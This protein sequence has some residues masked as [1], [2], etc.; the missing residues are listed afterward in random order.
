MANRKI[1]DLTALTAPATGDLL[2]IV[3][4]SEAAAADKNKKITYGELLASAPAGS[5]AAPS[6]SFDSDPNTGIYSPGADQV[7]ISTNGVARLTSSTTALTSAL[8]VD[9]PLGAAATP[10]LTFT[11]DLNTGIYSP[12][13]DQV[14]ISTGGTGRLF[15]DAAGLVGIGTSSPS[16]ILHVS[17]TSG[18]PALFE[19]TGSNG[20]FIGLKDGSVNNVFLGNTNGV[21]SVQ[22]PGSSFSDK[23]VVTSAGLVGIGTT[24]P[25]EKLEIQDGS[26]SVGS[27]ANTSQ[28]NTLI[29]GYGYILSG[30]KYGNT[31]IRSTYNN[32]NNLSSLEFYTSSSATASTE[33]LRI[34]SAGLVGVGTSAPA[35]TLHVAGT[36][37]NTGQA[38]LGIGEATTLAYIGDPFTTN[39]RSIIFN[40]ATGVTDIVNIQGL[41]AGVGLT[42]IALQAGGGRVGIGTSS[43]NAL[44]EVNSSTAGNE[45]QRIEGAYS[46]SGSV[47]LTNWRRAGGA[48][49]AAFKYND[50]TSPL[51]MSIGTTTSHQFRIRTADTDAITIDTS[52]RVGI[53]T[54]SPAAKLEVA[55]GNI[56]LDNNQGVEWGGVNNYIY[57]NESTDF[58]AV[59][60]NGN[61]RSR[62]D[63]SGRLL[64]GTST[65]LGNGDNVQ[66][67]KLQVHSS[68]Y[69]LADF[70]QYSADEYPSII[71]LEKS[72]N[73]SVG[74]HTALV[75]NDEIGSIR[76]AGSDGTRFQSAA[77]IVAQVDG[78]PGANDM[79]GRLVFSTTADGASSPTERMRIASNGKTTIKGSTS[80]SSAYSLEVTESG[81]IV[82]FTIRNDGIILTGTDTL[83]PYNNTTASAANLFVTSGGELQRST[84]S[85]KYKKNVQDAPYGLQELMALRAV[86]YQGKS[87][88]DGNT[89]YG[90]LIAEEVDAAGLQEFVQYADDGTPDALAYGNMV[91]LCIK[92]IQEQQAMI[93]ELQ[94]KVA[95]FESA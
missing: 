93:A 89:V 39:T 12:G 19:R 59:A 43:V 55:G 86:T 18:T 23:L 51:C 29:A 13:A 84:S 35:S 87:A 58:I 56:R 46:G 49:A 15:I 54:A 90:G 50:G 67:A 57:G 9:V 36:F 7:A 78:T 8:A 31:S 70:A 3:D 10:S 76:F 27:S 48:V 94:A 73:A 68:A 26:I 24:I 77:Y 25:L 14:A 61:E 17:G 45:V 16:N 4:I 75:N 21:F 1:S 44:L 53:G 91:S 92:A 66:N 2:P 30:T 38:Y 60:T 22:T 47:T 37:R 80:D 95:V 40:R 41:N 28:A 72:R 71:Y 6:F 5:A 64:V 65:A 74:S 32:A 42:D 20:V 62:W 63:S 83:S 79:P 52:Q 81:G 88:S 69:Y 82:Q 11:G 85:L 34:T 33:R